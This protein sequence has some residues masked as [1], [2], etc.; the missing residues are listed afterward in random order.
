MA[1][2]RLNLGTG[3]L[4]DAQV[5]KKIDDGIETLDQ[6]TSE[7]LTYIT[8]EMFGAV[9]NGTA[10]DS[11]A[12]QAMINH[13]GLMLC[14]KTYRI[15]K[16]IYLRDPSIEGDTGAFKR[17]RI[18]G[19]QSIINQHGS[20]TQIDWLHNNQATFI[21]DGGSFLVKYTC[22]VSF[23][24]CV[25]LGAKTT[26]MTETCFKATEGVF[27]RIE[28]RNCTFANFDTAIR[29]VDV[30]WSGECIFDH[31]YFTLCNTCIFMENGGYDCLFEGMIAQGNCGYFLKLT[32][33]NNALITANHDYSSKGSIIYGS[34]NITGNYF[35]GINKLHIKSATSG[36]ATLAPTITSN[37]FLL[38]N[39]STGNKAMFIVDERLTGATITGNTMVGGAKTNIVMFDVDNCSY[40]YHNI[41]KNNTGK[42]SALFSKG[43]NVTMTAN[44][45]HLDKT[46]MYFD[47]GSGTKNWEEIFTFGNS[48]MVFMD[49]TTP[50]SLYFRGTGMEGAYAS[51]VFEADITYT[52]GTVEH[53]VSRLGYDLSKF[54]DD[55]SL[56]ERMQIKAWVRWGNPSANNNTF[57]KMKATY[58]L[59]EPA[60]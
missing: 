41:I 33:A 42:I 24:D 17:G 31:L 16:D 43:V 25:F 9:G 15:T 52:D 19:C 22:Q 37:T 58:E 35:D 5:F 55:W 26:S 2:E 49:C 36:N 23:S 40:F 21:M 51:H 34:A 59:D 20:N 60:D 6:T 39:E 45:N 29:T 38:G 54:V 57:M 10:D 53:R 11:D 18:M 46:Y 13:G 27:R 1:Y 44:G 56:V 8:P 14:L 30:T 50:S 4:L 32:G 47:V 48:A 28:I 12:I 3:D 7:H